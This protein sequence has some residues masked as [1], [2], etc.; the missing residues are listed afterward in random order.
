[1]LKKGHC[2]LYKAPTKEERKGRLGG[3]GDKIKFIDLGFERWQVLGFVKGRRRQDVPRKERM[4]K[5]AD[6]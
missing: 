4:V 1:M 5:R 3:E 6:S 2:G